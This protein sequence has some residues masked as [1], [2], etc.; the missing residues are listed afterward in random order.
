LIAAKVFV[1]L[2]IKVGAEN[3]LVDGDTENFVQLCTHNLQ[4]ISN[5]FG[6]EW[7]WCTIV[8]EMAYCR[9][10]AKKMI[11]HKPLLILIVERIQRNDDHLLEYDKILVALIRYVQWIKNTRSEENLLE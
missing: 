9:V 3:L 5:K 11:C 8:L 2:T 4:N 7:S 10:F 6:F 1:W